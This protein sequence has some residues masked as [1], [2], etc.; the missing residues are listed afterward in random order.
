MRISGCSALVEAV[1]R[2]LIINAAQ[3]VRLQQLSPESSIDTLIFENGH[4]AAGVGLAGLTGGNVAKLMARILSGEEITEEILLGDWSSVEDAVLSAADYG[5]FD[6]ELC[7]VPVM[8]EDGAQAYEVTVWLHHD[9][10]K[11][12]ITALVDGLCVQ[13]DA[14]ALVTRENAE[15][16]AEIYAVAL[17][18]IDAQTLLE[19]SLIRTPTASVDSAAEGGIYDVTGR[20]ALT[21]LHAGEGAYRIVTIE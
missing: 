7:I 4:A 2:S 5:R 11:L 17:E 9:G 15:T 21:A 10:V 12:N 20:D 18:T 14:S 19:S 8:L 16:F 6:L 13:L 3:L 1:Q